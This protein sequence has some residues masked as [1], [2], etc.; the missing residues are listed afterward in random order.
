MLTLQFVQLG[1]QPLGAFVQHPAIQ[2]ELTLA[3]AAA[4]AHAALLALQMAPRPHETC[5]LI[6]HAR[7]F[8]LHLADVAL[9]ALA[10]NIE[11]EAGPVHHVAP[12]KTLE[13]TLLSRTQR[14]V[15]DDDFR[16]FL[17][18]G[19]PHLFRLARADE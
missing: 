4:Q 18:C 9:G 7:K 10:E 12:E 15:E 3:R 19:N 2:F 8:H 13:V 11:D 16:V 14:V 5:C 6:S 17:V 1:R